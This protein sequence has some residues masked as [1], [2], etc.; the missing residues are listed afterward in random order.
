MIGPSGRKIRRDVV[1]TNGAALVRY[2]KSLPGRKQPGGPVLGAVRPALLS[3]LN[4]PPYGR[5]IR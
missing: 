4:P 5:K 2:M 3:G 1:E